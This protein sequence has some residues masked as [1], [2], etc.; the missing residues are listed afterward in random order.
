VDC[1]R[2]AVSGYSQIIG[3]LYTLNSGMFQSPIFCDHVLTQALVHY[4]AW[5]QDPAVRLEV[6]PGAQWHLLEDYRVER[7]GDALYVAAAETTAPVRVGEKIVKVN[8]KTL[9]AIRPEVERMLHT[10]VVPSDP[11]REDWALVLAFA[12]HLTVVGADGAERTIKVVPGRSA[13]TERMKGVYAARGEGPAPVAA[14]DVRPAGGG[15]PVDLSAVDGTW[16][17][18]LAD[19]GAADFGEA[20]GRAL[21]ELTE[22]MGRGAVQGLVIDVRGA[23]GGVFEDVYPLVPHVT[24]AGSTCGPVEAF[25]RTG[26]VLNCS[27]HNVDERLG[28]LKALRRA[29]TSDEELAQIDALADELT[30]RRACGLV[31]DEEDYYAQATFEGVAGVRGRTVLLVDRR[32]AGA[33]EWLARAARRLGGALVAGR[34]TRGSLDNT[35]LRALK[36]DD[37]FTLVF[38]TAKYRWAAEGDG[39]LGRGVAPDVHL[40][41]TPEQLVRDVDLDAACALARAAR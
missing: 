11:E 32:T 41:W 13:V 16:V 14:E 9:D 29:C 34:A 28:A 40:P 10:T 24:P 26:I 23:H 27:R 19:P 5:Y 25:G 39:T 6:G 8:G 37:D 4:L 31:A 2:F 30:A 7:F 33:A 18:R 35:C 38:P 20:L 36:L 15:T 22:Q 1:A 21:A 3:Q 17:L 12:K